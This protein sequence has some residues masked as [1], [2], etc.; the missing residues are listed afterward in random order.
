MTN[1][2]SASPKKD[3]AHDDERTQRAGASFGERA[4][5]GEHAGTEAPHGLHVRSIYVRAVRPAAREVDAVAST[6][7]VDSYGEIVRANWDLRRF[8]ANP[9]ILWAHNRYEDRL[10]V[11]RAKDVRVDNGVLLMTIVFDSVTE[12]DEQVFQK[13]VG[14]TLKGFSV[15]FNPRTIA[16]EKIDGQE[17]VVLD[18]NELF[19]VSCVPIPS[20]P[21]A[22]ARARTRAIEAAREAARNAAPSRP[23]PS[24]Q[25]THMKEGKIKK[26]GDLSC[27]IECPHC[28]G[29]FEMSADVMPVPP[30]KAAELAEETS[31]RAAAEARIKALETR[32][33]ELVAQ[34]VAA[35]A[36]LAALE[37]DALI[38]VKIAPVERETL[39]ELAHVYLGQKEGDV[40]WKK[41]LDGIRARADMKLVGP[42]VTTK[43][44]TPPAAPASEPGTKSAPA[45]TRLAQRLAK[46]ATQ[47]P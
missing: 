19:E 7:A 20:N 26:A 34:L 9:V 35:R 6:E 42:P 36:E 23:T 8:L 29:D 15:G 12:F 41:H 21:E 32:E 5:A 30:K 33:G 4:R 46:S 11:G 2:A 38:G 44:P 10:P 28:A 27:S 45:A 14:G 17:V 40:K 1:S 25:G 24:P 37:V 47:A 13:Y 18:D 39:L 22:L 43:D 3:G 16:V 31:L